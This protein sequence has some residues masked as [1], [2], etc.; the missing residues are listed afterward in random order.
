M[1]FI[2]GSY[3]GFCRFGGLPA[4]PEQAANLV[5]LVLTVIRK[6]PCYVHEVCRP[7]WLIPFHR[8][9]VFLTSSLM[10]PPALALPAVT[11][12]SLRTLPLPA[13]EQTL[14]WRM[15]M[16]AASPPSIQGKTG[17]NR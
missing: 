13:Q 16:V 17:S 6:T 7:R 2:C 9:Y 10:P 11:Y 15:K 4:T 8:Q 5:F 12:S 3:E 14:D 1:P